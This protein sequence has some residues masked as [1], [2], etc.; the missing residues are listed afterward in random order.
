METGPD[1]FF[2]E[3]VF[4]AISFFLFDSFIP[5]STDGD[6]RRTVMRGHFSGVLRGSPGSSICFVYYYPKNISQKYIFPQKSQHYIQHS[7]PH[8]KDIFQAEMNISEAGKE[9]QC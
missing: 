9:P 1:S 5:C 3:T 7:T 8:H 4:L 6:V 2:L